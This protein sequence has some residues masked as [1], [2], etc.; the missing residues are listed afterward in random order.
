MAGDAPSNAFKRACAIQARIS[1][2]RGTAGEPNDKL[3]SATRDPHRTFGLKFRVRIRAN[4]NIDRPSSAKY[5][6]AGSRSL[7]ELL[8]DPGKNPRHGPYRGKKTPMQEPSRNSKAWSSSLFS[9][10][11][12]RL[13]VT[14]GGREVRVV[15]EHLDVP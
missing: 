8:F 5:S 7:S 6:H 3:L 13:D 11:S 15:G 14:T 1:A 9:P 10:L 4:S 2:S 12:R